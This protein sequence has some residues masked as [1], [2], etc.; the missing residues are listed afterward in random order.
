[1]HS[2][3]QKNFVKMEA[4]FRDIA[5]KALEFLKQHLTILWQ[6]FIGLGGFIFIVYSGSIKYIPELSWESL[7]ILLAVVALLGIYLTFASAFTLIVP[8]IIWACFINSGYLDDLFANSKDLKA[9]A[10]QILKFFMLPFFIILL[11]IPAVPYIL[12]TVPYILPYQL[13]ITLLIT[14]P[15]FLFLIAF[16]I[17]I[18][19]YLHSK[20]SLSEFFS[21]RFHRSVIIALVLNYTFSFILGISSLIYVHFLFLHSETAKFPGVILYLISVVFITFIN[22]LVTINAKLSFYL[23]PIIAFLFFIGLINMTQQ[24]ALIPKAVMRGFGLGGALDIQIVLNQEGTTLLEKL[25]LRES[26]HCPKDKVN[27][28]SVRLLS[29]LGNEFFLEAGSTRFVLP[30]SMILSWAVTP[31]TQS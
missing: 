14:V 22:G 30:K 23:T 11:L 9:Y 12:N 27:V 10:I 3:S 4:Y 29:R 6:L 19:W 13:L 15:I 26:K 24:W 8:G 1:M 18:L 20:L 17:V 2:E 31:T 28:C 25:G 7:L 16:R 21:F 5:V